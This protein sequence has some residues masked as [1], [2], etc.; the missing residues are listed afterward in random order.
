M[1]SQYQQIMLLAVAVEHML[2]ERALDSEAQPLEDRAPERLLFDHLDDHLRRTQL[3]R[4]VED[5][6]GQ[7]RAEPRAA[8]IRADDQLNIA[9][10]ARPAVQPPHRAIADD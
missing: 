10:M 9:D 6:L 2:A 3:A 8:P 4:G 5:R 1:I 7:N